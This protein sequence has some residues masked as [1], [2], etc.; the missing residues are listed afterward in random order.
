VDAATVA[1]DVVVAGGDDVGWVGGGLVVAETEHLLCAGLPGERVDLLWEVGLRRVDLRAHTRGE[2][3]NR[4][5]EEG[6]A[7]EG[8]RRQSRVAA[9]NITGQGAICSALHEARNG[10]AARRLTGPERPDDPA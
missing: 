6:L 8:I 4:G 10:V 5:V 3:I 2:G 1:D 9:A 7:F